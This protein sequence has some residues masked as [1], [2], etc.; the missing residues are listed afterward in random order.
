MKSN[1]PPKPSLAFGTALARAGDIVNLGDRY[2][3]LYETVQLGETA[4]DPAAIPVR[5]SAFYTCGVR[6]PYGRD[7]GTFLTITAP[8]H[9]ECSPEGLVE[10]HTKLD[11]ALKNSAERGVAL[12][13][14]TPDVSTPLEGA[15]S[16]STAHLNVEAT[17]LARSKKVPLGIM[18]IWVVPG[19]EK[20]PIQRTLQSL[21]SAD[22]SGVLKAI[23]STLK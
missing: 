7:V 23:R 15:P 12:T 20:A 4:I 16:G 17:D 21:R 3:A 9:V 2:S 5:M 13:T 19:S 18:A 11:E 8:V 10:L 6:P 22:P 14:A 1:I